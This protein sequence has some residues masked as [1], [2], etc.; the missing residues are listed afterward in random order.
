MNRSKW[1]GPFIKQELFNQIAKLEINKN[2][3]FIKT[4]S[5][6][7]DSMPVLVGLRFQVYNG[8]KFKNLKITD[9][10]VGY[11]IGEFINTR[12][13]HIRNYIFKV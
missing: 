1:K 8:K 7:S 2:N 13:K 10:M 12:K 4:F 11:K 9:E 3:Y 5:K 6:E